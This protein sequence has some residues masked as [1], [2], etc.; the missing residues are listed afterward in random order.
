MIAN[1]AGLEVGS[2]LWADFI[3]CLG[4]G[5]TADDV[6][7]CFIPVGLTASACWAEVRVVLVCESIG[8]P[9]VVEGFAC[10]GSR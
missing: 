3:V 7:D 5:W 6:C 4:T 8:I 1:A 10:M 2:N 9:L